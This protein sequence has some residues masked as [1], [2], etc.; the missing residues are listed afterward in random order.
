MHKIREKLTANFAK[1]SRATGLIR[2]KVFYQILLIVAI[3]VIFLG[4]QAYMNGA[5]IN[6]MQN[7][8]KTIFVDGSDKLN[9][10]ARLK[11]DI[12]TIQTG[13]SEAVI[14][15]GASSYQLDSNLNAKFGIVLEWLDEEGKKDISAKLD[16]IKELFKA[17]P[18]KANYQHVK[19]GLIELNYSLDNIQSRISSAMVAGIT[20]NERFLN[21]SRTNGLIMML[22]GFI[23]SI[24]IGLVIVHSIATPLKQMETAARAIASGDLTQNITTSGAPEILRAVDGLNR[25]SHSLL[26]LV[27]NINSEATELFLAGRKLQTA[28]AETGNSASEVA[29]TMEELAKGSLQQTTQI[30][31][32]ANTVHFLSDLVQGVSNDTEAIFAAAAKTAQTA[33]EGLKATG[34]MA[35]EI[36]ELFVAT[37]EMGGVI[38]ELGR[39]SDEINNV[40]SVIRNIAEQT[41]LL[42]LNAAIEAA[43]AGEHGKGFAVVSRETGKLADQS[44]QAVD[45]VVGLVTHIK[46]STEQAVNTI[47][48]GM[49]RAENGKNLA[50]QTATTFEAIFKEIDENLAQIDTVAQSARKMNQSNK[51]VIEAINEIA[52]ISQENLASNE[53]VSAA[54]EEQSAAT[55]QVTALADQLNQ[56][57]NHLQGAVTVFKLEP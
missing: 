49:A 46:E 31:Q 54:T 8:V 6:T 26:E 9:Q 11:Q 25:A 23:F 1:I 30:S 15:E 32:A 28:A 44:K 40:I 35:D 37:K 24:C 29:R 3:M 21:E 5:I 48:K 27:R 39:A 57:A 12:A 52:A 14:H 53:E 36:Q 10:I 34:D 55:Q 18:N 22:V 47:Q 43:R 7:A 33:R 19:N 4:V 38:T 13:Y 17:L 16:S 50:A 41:S 51:I 2:L 56:I 45:L 42:A 20:N